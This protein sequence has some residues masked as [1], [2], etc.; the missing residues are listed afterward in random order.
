MLLTLQRTKNRRQ[1]VRMRQL[2]SNFCGQPTWKPLYHANAQYRMESSLH[3]KILRFESELEPIW[4]RSVPRNTTKLFGNGSDQICISSV[5][6]YQFYRNS[7]KTC[8][9]YRSD[10]DMCVLIWYCPDATAVLIQCWKYTRNKTFWQW[11]VSGQN[12]FGCVSVSVTSEI[13]YSK[14][15]KPPTRDNKNP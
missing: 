13:L 9:S 5:A 7:P 15:S 4:S 12:I 14:D 1:F 3:S 8:Y 2:I 6:L 11:T 10:T